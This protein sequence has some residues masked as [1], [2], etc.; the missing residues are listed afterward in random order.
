MKNW[1]LR[2][3]M[4]LIII[5]VAF[6]SRIVGNSDTIVA[7]WANSYGY[8]FYCPYNNYLYKGPNVPEQFRNYPNK[9]FPYP[10]RSM[11]EQYPCPCN[12]TG[13]NL[14]LKEQDKQ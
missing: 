14:L 11:L 3:L 1:L 13:I 8:F 7:G 5:I 6:L 9:R 4:V 2:I 10:Y 12:T